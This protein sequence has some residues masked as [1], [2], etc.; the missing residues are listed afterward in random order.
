M[1][2]IKRLSNVVKGS[3]LSSTRARGDGQLSEQELAAELERQP[4]SRAAHEE[5]SR[6]KRSMAGP[7]PDQSVHQDSGSDADSLERLAEAFTR[8]EIDQQA[9]EDRRQQLMTDTSPSPPKRTL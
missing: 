2:F 6:R 8:G 3:V 5:L 1:S 9:Y 4:P 7:Q